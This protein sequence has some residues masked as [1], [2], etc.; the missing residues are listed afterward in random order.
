MYLKHQAPIAP[1]DSDTRHVVV[2]PTLMRDGSSA[3]VE[4]VYEVSLLARRCVSNGGADALLLL[5]QDDQT[6]FAMQLREAHASLKCQ[7]G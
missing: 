3:N 2:A 1:L 7:T 5:S 4:P 6:L